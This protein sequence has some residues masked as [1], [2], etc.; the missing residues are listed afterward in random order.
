MPSIAGGRTSTSS[1]R[2]FGE[3]SATF[4]AVIIIP[5]LVAL[6]VLLVYCV[7]CR[8]RKGQAYAFNFEDPDDMPHR[9][10]SS[11]GSGV[12]NMCHRIFRANSP[13]PT[14]LGPVRKSPSPPREGTQLE[15]EYDETNDI[16]RWLYMHD[17]TDDLVF[18]SPKK[19]DDSQPDRVVL[20]RSSSLRGDGSESD[21]EAGG[22]QVSVRVK[23]KGSGST[24]STRALPPGRSRSNVRALF[25]SDDGDA[26]STPPRENT[27]EAYGTAL[28]TMSD[29]DEVVF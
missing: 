20:P 8:R 14:S 7:Y 11:P 18:V 2:S 22:G 10:E 15:E 17:D 27:R 26:E 4:I 3:G 25:D 5:V 16:S 19:I 29:D 21:E 24:K 1:I 23:A 9:E 28:V 13:L 6:A 12:V